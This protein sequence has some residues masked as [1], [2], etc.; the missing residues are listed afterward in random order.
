[1]CSKNMCIR[2]WCGVFGRSEISFRELILLLPTTKLRIHHTGLNIFNSE[3]KL[4]PTLFNAARLMTLTPILSALRI[5]CSICLLI[6]SRAN[7]KKYCKVK[8]TNFFKKNIA[9][10]K[11]TKNFKKNITRANLKAISGHS[12]CLVQAASEVV[13]GN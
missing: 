4:I 9:L 8:K 1:M 11:I 12:P 6:P 5:A 3:R 2:F 7:G 10:I 13:K